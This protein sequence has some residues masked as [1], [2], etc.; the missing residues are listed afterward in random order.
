[1]SKLLPLNLFGKLQ[2]VTNAADAVSCVAHKFWSYFHVVILTHSVDVSSTDFRQQTH[3]QRDM[4]CY[5]P[6]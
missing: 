1:M 2:L 4:I 3:R 5:F 6:Y